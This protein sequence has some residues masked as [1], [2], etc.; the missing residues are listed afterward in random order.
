MTKKISISAESIFNALLI[1]FSLFVIYESWKMGFGTLARPGSGLFVIACG[2]AILL[3]NLKILLKKS[4]PTQASIL[5]V[6]EKKKFLIILV[7]FLGW[8]FFIDWLGYVLV[9][10][11]ATVYL[12]KVLG[13]PGWRQ[14]LLLAFGTALAC[15]LLFDYILY[16]D[17]PRGFWS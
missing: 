16:L 6:R 13:L 7:T 12:S 14:S 9:T 8:L 10:F 4:H 11:L 15:Y 3:L 1:F 2:V 5:T 17:L